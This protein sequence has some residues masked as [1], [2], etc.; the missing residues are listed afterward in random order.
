VGKGIYEGETI[1]AKWTIDGVAKQH[2]YE[3]YPSVEREVDVGGADYLRKVQGYIDRL[4]EEMEE[5]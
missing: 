4:I 1:V 5:E 2:E 3:D